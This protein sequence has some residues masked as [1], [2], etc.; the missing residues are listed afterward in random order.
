MVTGRPSKVVFI[1]SSLPY[2][3]Y[4][5]GD[6]VSRTDRQTDRP[7]GREGERETDTE[8]ETEKN[9]EGEERNAVYLCVLRI[10]SMP[11]PPSLS[12]SDTLSD[13]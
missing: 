7:R 12:L 4:R 8:R 2:K 11:T 10:S 13:Q 6:K 1:V 3:R 9:R 5:E